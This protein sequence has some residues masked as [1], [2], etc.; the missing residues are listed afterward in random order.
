M[1]SQVQ[2]PVSASKLK[3][4]HS[5]LTPAKIIA[6]VE[7]C[8]VPGRPPDTY[9]FKFAAGRSA[10]AVTSPFPVLSLAAYSQ[11]CSLVCL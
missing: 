8:I 1:E 6:P 3:E 9:L 10:R 11:Y 2:P 4:T 7:F 5:L